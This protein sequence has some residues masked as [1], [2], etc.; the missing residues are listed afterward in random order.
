M[1]RARALAVATLG[2]LLGLAAGCGES[3]K[4][5]PVSGGVKLNG[6]PDPNAGVLCQP[7]GGKDNIN[8]GRGSAGITDDNG[9]FTLKT[10]DGHTGA[11]VGTH[12]VSIRTNSGEAVGYDPEVGSADNAPGPEKTKLDPIPTEWRALSGKQTHQGSPGGA[13]QGPLPFPQPAA[14]GP[15]R[16]PPRGPSDRPGRP[17]RPRPRGR[18]RSRSPPVVPGRLLPDCLVESF[19][20]DAVE[21]WRC[22]PPP[23]PHTLGERGRDP[24]A[25]MDSTKQCPT[26]A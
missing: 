18:G 21:E 9:R 17:T 20:N 4:Y 23:L 3:S 12:Q 24:H 2:L 26:G 8:P 1:R 13:R 6:K 25:A 15:R 16:P 5:V 22:R 7:V 19:P 10:D 14:T 11:V